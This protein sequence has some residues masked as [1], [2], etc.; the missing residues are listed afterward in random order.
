MWPGFMLMR[1]KAWAGEV[2]DREL[3]AG[4]AVVHIGDGQM[5]FGENWY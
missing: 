4:Q 5:L 3:F 2:N 1:A